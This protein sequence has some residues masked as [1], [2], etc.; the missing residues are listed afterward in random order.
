MLPYPILGSYFLLLHSEIQTSVDRSVSYIKVIF[1]VIRHTDKK[2]E[3]GAVFLST[4]ASYR[5]KRML[6]SCFVLEK[7]Q[8]LK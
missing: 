4:D 3:M 8:I 2:G 5:K 1:L 6:Y 7:T